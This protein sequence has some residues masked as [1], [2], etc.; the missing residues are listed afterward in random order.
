MGFRY[1]VTGLAATRPVTGYVMNLSDG[2]VVVEMEGESRAIEDFVTAIQDR[3]SGYIRETHIDRRPASG[4]HT[5]FRVRY[6]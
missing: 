5:G 6:E 1:T 2:R 3:M 4:A